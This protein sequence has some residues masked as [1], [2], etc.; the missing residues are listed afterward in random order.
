MP[1]GNL[2]PV[3]GLFCGDCEFY[4]IKCKG[5][6]NVKGKPFW[7]AQVLVKV[8]PLYDCCIN[9]KKVEHCGECP[10]IPCKTFNEFY[11]PALS[12]EQ[13]KEAVN[14]RKKELFKRK[15]IGT[16]NWLKDK[17]GF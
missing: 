8:C 12:S 5:C 13:A 17:A 3:C 10:E 1:D 15:N 16:D 14:L 9:L 4:N 7:T 11:D 6:G 2:A